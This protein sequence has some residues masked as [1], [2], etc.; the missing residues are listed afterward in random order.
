[1]PDVGRDAPQPRSRLELHAI[2]FRV[3]R[4]ADTYAAFY[5]TMA[6]GVRSLRDGGRGLLWN[7]FQSCGQPFLA[8]FASAQLYP[9]YALSL[10]VG[11]P[12]ALWLIPFFH[13]LVAGLSTYL[14]CR[15][16][17]VGRAAAL[18]GAVAFQLGN[19]TMETAVW[20]PHASGSFVWLPAAMLF[21]ERALRRPTAPNA[22]GLAAALGLALL[23]GYPQVVFY[24]YLLVAARLAW[25]LA[26]HWRERPGPVL[27]AV[28]SGIALAPPLAPG[29]LRRGIERARCGPLHPPLTAAE[30]L[31]TRCL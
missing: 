13:L 1:M 31:R 16:L 20:Q 4:L 9:P 18:C 29:Q 25:H 17:G 10:L 22:I 6:Y 26:S 30:R 11:G 15:E 8:R 14:L 12:L 24:T 7:P 27:L 2:M 21:C 23:A 28:A 19:A 5:P 3:G